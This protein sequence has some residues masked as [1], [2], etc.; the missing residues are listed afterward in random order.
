MVI[1]R[2]AA[3]GR[4]IA[5]LALVLLAGCGASARTS[6]TQV[7]SAP[8]SGAPMKSVMVFAAH[9][10]EANRRTLEDAYVTALAQH[11]VTAKQSYTFFPGEPPPR[12]QA[13][14]VLKKAGIEGVLVST[15]RGVREKQTYLS[16]YEGGLWSGY[17][18]PSGGTSSPGYLISDEVVSVDTTLWDARTGDQLVFTITT[19]TTNPSSGKNF[20]PS[21]TDAV[22]PALENQKLIPPKR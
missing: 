2:R 18:G 8:V 17:Y 1:T 4:P 22:V 6:V 9:M 21:V 20:V 14:E 15:L 16:G 7:W 3:L 11:E 12:E 5:A 19:T 10:D 13:R